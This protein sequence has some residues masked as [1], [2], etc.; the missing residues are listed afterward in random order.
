MNYVNRKEML[1]VEKA[2]AFDEVV[3]L[4]EK[5]VDE[6]MSRRPRVD[7][8]ADWEKDE[9]RDFFLGLVSHVESLEY[10]IS[11]EADAWSRV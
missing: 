2:R 7:E 8:S 11:M 6:Y 1:M 5:M 4:T 9:L 3:E 10:S